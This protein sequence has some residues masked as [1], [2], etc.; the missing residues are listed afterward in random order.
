MSGAALAAGLAAAAAAWL[1]TA[2]GGRRAV[3]ALAAPGGTAAVRP[4]RPRRRPGAR[5]DGDAV[6]VR[7]VVAQVAA[8]LRS[9]APPG[10]AWTR[11]TGVP[12]DDA[13][14]PDE[15]ALAPVVGGEGHARSVVAATRLALDV[16]APLGRV[17]EAVSDTLVAEAEAQAERDAALAGPRATARVLQW[18]PAAGALLG[19][20][21]GADPL[22]TATDGGAGSA[23]VG[24]GLVLLAAGRW[25]TGRLVAA[26]RRAG[27]AS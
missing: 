7:V 27:E 11:A 6:Q 15:V 3:V 16:G 2:P 5:V 1:A 20:V 25:W 4:G 24:L 21:L 22:A 14:V 26:A 8:L 18:L 23:A 12:V 9:G 13:G 17:L 10:A 19:W